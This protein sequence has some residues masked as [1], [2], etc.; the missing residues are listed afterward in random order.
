MDVNMFLYC[1]WLAVRRGEFDE[2]TWA[3]TI[4][5]STAWAGKLVK[6]LRHARTWMKHE[7]CSVGTI[8]TIACMRLREKVKS[9]EFDAEKMQQE[10]LESL[11]N[12]SEINER[13]GSA[14]FTAVVGNVRRYCRHLELPT[15]NDVSEKVSVIIAAAHPSLD[16]REIFD[17]F[18]ANQ[19]T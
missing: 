6:P 13:N 7:G 1:C 2:Q 17:R 19:I 18:V 12:L 16:R 3:D 10:V 4:E 14:L 11:T 15:T 5:F 8:P 9:V